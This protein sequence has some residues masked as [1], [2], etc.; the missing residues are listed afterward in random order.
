MGAA[1]SK[2]SRFRK[3]LSDLVITYTQIG[4][5]ANAKLVGRISENFI[6][7]RWFGKSYVSNKIEIRNEIRFILRANNSFA[8]QKGESKRRRTYSQE[9][10]VV[11]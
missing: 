6:S 9:P 1:P 3:R 8:C 5:L 10:A 7:I 11:V 4:A 2:D